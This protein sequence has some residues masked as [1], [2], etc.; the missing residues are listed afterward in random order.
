MPRSPA[1]EPTPCG[2]PTIL[3]RTKKVRR[4]ST[5][6]RR[7]AG[8]TWFVICWTREP[9]LSSSMPT[10]RNRSM[11]WAPAAMAEDEVEAELRRLALPRATMLGAEPEVVAALGVEAPARR[12]QLRFARCSKQRRRRSNGL[13]AVAL[14]ETDRYHS[15]ALTVR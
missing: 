12:L 2:F 9:I 3:L 15:A 10:A 13:F 4:P 6:P 8:R 5:K 11:W 7:R 1:R 14:I